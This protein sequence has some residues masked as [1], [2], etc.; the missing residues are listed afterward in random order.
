[1]PDCRGVDRH[2]QVTWHPDTSTVVF[3]HWAGDVCTASTP[4]ALRDATEVVNVLVR[5]LAEAASRPVATT[6]AVRRLGSNSLLRLR[7]RLRPRLAEVVDATAVLLS[8]V[9]HGSG[10]AQDRGS[11]SS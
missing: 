5:A 6:L 2:L 8:R 7:D 1:M 10:Q 4:V 11:R 9:G 3:S